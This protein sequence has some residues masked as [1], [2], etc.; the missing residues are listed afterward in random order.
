METPPPKVALITLYYSNKMPNVF[1]ISA[2]T[3][4]STLS[5][6]YHSDVSPDKITASKLLKK[7][8]EI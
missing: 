7:F 8:I 3:S 1:A 5:P 6:L 4:L 2:E